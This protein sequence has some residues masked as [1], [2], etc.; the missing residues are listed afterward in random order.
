MVGWVSRNLLHGT[1]IVEV[2]KHAYLQVCLLTS[3]YGPSGLGNGVYACHS[4]DC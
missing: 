3:A 2:G 4:G 1:T